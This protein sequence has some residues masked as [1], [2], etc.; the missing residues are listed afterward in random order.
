MEGIR[1]Q[2]TPW[3]G[4]IY[5]WDAMVIPSDLRRDGMAE[6]AAPLEEFSLYGGFTQDTVTELVRLVTRTSVTEVD[7]R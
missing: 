3:T 5:P 7:A 2:L 1:G 4:A 6:P